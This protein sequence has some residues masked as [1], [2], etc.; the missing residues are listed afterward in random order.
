MPILEVSVSDQV[1][2]VQGTGPASMDVKGEIKFELKYFDSKRSKWETMLSHGT[3]QVR[4]KA[5][6]E[7]GRK[8]SISTGSEIVA[9]LSL[10]ATESIHAFLNRLAL[11]IAA[12]FPAHGSV[13]AF[14]I[15]NRS[16]LSM[17][18]FDHAPR[19]RNDH[20]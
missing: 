7:G 1:F 5:D 6:E 2:V 8:I 20:E 16:G 15:H 9:S 10:T 11:S 12:P 18:L 4:M 19:N 3:S 13:K 14:H 17:Y